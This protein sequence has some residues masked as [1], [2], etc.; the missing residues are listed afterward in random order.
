MNLNKQ[1]IQSNQNQNKSD[2]DTLRKVLTNRITIKIGFDS[3][4]NKVNIEKRTNPNEVEKQER[5]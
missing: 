5:M 4:V 1:I 2:I 3:Q